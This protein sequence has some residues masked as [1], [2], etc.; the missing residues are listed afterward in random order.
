M[1]WLPTRDAPPAPS[2]T[3][4]PAIET[5]N[6]CN[7][8]LLPCAAIPS[9]APPHPPPH[10]PPPPAAAASP[11]RLSRAP[12]PTSDPPTTHPPP[13]SSAAASLSPRRKI[14]PPARA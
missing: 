8:P 12:S 4:L 2:P 5:A 11:A 14:H 7:H 6:K 3:T 9:H 1:A 13:R 10:H